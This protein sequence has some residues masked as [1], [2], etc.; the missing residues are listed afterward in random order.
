[1]GGEYKF[2]SPERPVRIGIVGVG[3]I[4]QV[5][6]LPLIASMKEYTLVGLCD[7]E[8]FKLGQIAKKYKTH[9]FVDV[10]N[11]LHNC[12][13]DVVLICTPTLSHLPISLTALHYGAHVIVEKPAAMNLTE[14]IRLEEAARDSGLL[15]LVA[16]KHRFRNDVGIL[17]KFI[18]GEELG[19]IWR[20]RAGWLRRRGAWARNDWLD[21]KMISGGG[22]LM[23]LGV[24]L[25]DLVH[26][27]LGAK[28]VIR[29]SSYTHHS[30][31]GRDV[32][33]TVT[34]SMVYE[35]GATFHLDCSWGLYSEQDVAYTYFEGTQGS[36][37]LN[38]LI[39]YKTIQD[40]LVNVSPVHTVSVGEL[41][42]SSFRRQLK[43]FNRALR[44]EE[45]PV[46][47]IAE[48]RQTMQL[49]DY[50][51]KGAEECREI[52]PDES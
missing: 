18:E 14:T 44:G 35:D 23:D 25:V 38:P 32:E 15:V 47:T 7:T 41:Y 33:D 42:R 10:E 28:K 20:V 27:L 13:P 36:A 43:H 34:C 26:W 8:E 3:G 2:I 52:R 19:S 49:I 6:H 1:M 46:S 5:F 16:M 51:Y 37:Q 24:E 39:V 31:L 50:I 40:A 29:I 48:A 22:V 45:E 12:Q 21:Q 30:R 4:A 11:M 17:R 9:G